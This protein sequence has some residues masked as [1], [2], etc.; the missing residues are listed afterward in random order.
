VNNVYLLAEKVL[1]T[2]A[3]NSTV[4]ECGVFRGNTIFVLAEF[5]KRLNIEK[6]FMDMILLRVS[7]IQY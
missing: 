3:Q 2:K 4:V 5:C 1:A 7:P 6:K